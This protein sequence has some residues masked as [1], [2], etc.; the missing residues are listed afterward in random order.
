MSGTQEKLGVCECG[1]GCGCDG[2]HGTACKCNSADVKAKAE[3]KKESAHCTC[4]TKCVCPAQNEKCNCGEPERKVADHSCSC[5]SACKCPKGQ[6]RQATQSERRL[7]DLRKELP[8]Y[9]YRDEL[10]A[11]IEEYQ[12]LIVVGSGKTTQLPQYVV[13]GLPAIRNVCI[14]QPRRI[15]AIS[16]ARRVAEETGTRVG[17]LVGY[18]IRFEKQSSSSTRLLYVTDGTLLRYV[19]TDPQVRAYDLI[20]LDEAHERSLET[21]ILFALLRQACRL[22]PELKVVIMSAT[23]E[24]DRFA[25]Y[26][27][28]APVFS[29]PGRMY[30]VDIFWQK[31]MK[32][33]AAKATF[34]RRAVDT[35]LHIHKNEEPGDVLVFLTGQQEIEQATRLFQEAHEELD[36]DEVRYR[37]TVRDVAIFPIYSSLETLEQRAIFDHAPD[38]VRKIVFATNIA[39]TSVT[40]PGIRYVVDS[41]FVKQK[42]FDAQTG[43]DA[44]VVVP[45]SQAAATQRAGRAGRTAMGKVYRLYSREAFEGMD[46]AT[47]PEIQRSSLIGTVLSMKKMGI[48]DIINF[49][50]IDPPDPELIVAA[51]KSLFLLGAVDEHGHLAQLG[52]KMAELPISPFLSRVLISASL[53]FHCASE[54]LTIVSMLSVEEVFTTPR[55]K[56]KQAEAEEIRQ[57]FHDATGDH[58]TLLKIYQEWESDDFSKDW[59]YD[60]YLHYRAMKAA[61]KVREQLTEV[62]HKLGLPVDSSV[63]SRDHDERDRK[64]RR[65]LDG[66]ST[67]LRPSLDP[68][69]ILRAFCTAFYVN[70]AKRHTQRAVFYPY[71]PSV[72]HK[73]SSLAPTSTNTQTRSASQMLALTLHPQSS[74]AASSHPQCDFVIYNDVQYV[75]RANMRTVSKIRF[76][77]VEVLMGRLGLVDEDRLAGNVAGHHEGRRPSISISEVAQ[78]TADDEKSDEGSQKGDG[79]TTTPAPKPEFELVHEVIDEA[80][81]VERSFGEEIGKGAVV[82]PLVDANEGSSGLVSPRPHTHPHIAVGGHKEEAVVDEEARKREE[83]V[84][85]AKERYLKRKAGRS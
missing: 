13:E 5:G 34:L 49:E 84:R 22:R 82:S 47:I 23:L 40:I 53:D 83:A 67:H 7:A 63:A 58:L 26:F 66:R 3:S 48:E 78:L 9:T 70:T 71:A 12:F 57:R 35:V 1:V 45:I 73:S 29:I 65:R 17:D 31:K 10:L 37:S 42:M 85:A 8:I 15:A 43:V 44:L 11:A 33:G 4:G 52:S 50:F 59:A 2:A 68:T 21:D 32:L 76:E 36:Y 60:H 27:G 39:Q 46:P 79:E 6:C 16:A 74:L 56:R 77:W 38:G 14:T 64:R 41:G 80:H 25:A 72:A 19:A 62:M 81:Q 54:A 30:A 51:I 18:S 61:R 55:G 75:N 69:P 24:I 28:D 20:I